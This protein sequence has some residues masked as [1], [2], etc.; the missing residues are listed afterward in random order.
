MSKEARAGRDEIMECQVMWEPDSKRTTQMD[1]FRAVA[2]AACGLA[3]ENYNDLYHWSVASYSDFWAEFWKFSGLVFSRMYDEVVDTSKGIAEVPEWFPGSRLNYAENLLQHAKNDRVALYVAR[4]GRE[5]I[6][7]LT[8]EE[9]RQ[10]VALFAAAMRKMGVR[11]GDRV[12]GY[13]PNGAHAVEA[14]LAAASIGAIWS[15]TSP[16]FGVNGVLDRFSQIQPKVLFSVEAVVYNGKEHSHMEKLQRVVRGLPDLKKVVVIPYVATRETIDISKIPNSV[17]LDDFLATGMG[18]QAPQLEFEQLPFN[19]PLFIMFSSGTT[20]A[21]KCMVHSAGGTLIQHLKEHLLHGD[22]TSGDVLLYY[23]TVGWM[24]WNWM[25]SALATGAS[26]VLYDGSP[27]VPTPNV[28]WDL[29]DRIGIT[30]LGTGAK[31]LSVLEEKDMK[32]VETHSLQTLR[33]ILSTGSPLKAQ[34]YDYVY[35]CIKSSVLLGSISGGTDIISCFMGHNPSIPVHRGEIQARN[36]AMAV[37]A[38][39]EE[40]RAVW[41]QS[42]EL[43]CTKPLPCQPTHFWNDEN[44]SKYRKAYFSKFPGVWAH[45]D[46]CRINPKTGG[47]VMLGRSD[48][49]LNPNG[50]RFGSSEIYNIVYAQWQEGGGGCETGHCGEG[51]GAAWGLLQPREPGPV[52]GHPRAAGLLSQLVCL[53][54]GHTHVHRTLHIPQSCRSLWARMGASRALSCWWVSGI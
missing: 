23:T 53:L 50:V 35:K 26:L 31:W 52:L 48:G 6:V 38:W 21:P 46:Y 9:L 32:P 1:R 8:F 13:L 28:L 25:V 17:F 10:Q 12:V 37:E 34:S 11:T 2:G 49:T 7:K 41:G 44:G 43:V 29:V 20:G 22:V 54:P 24:M 33:T 47:I 15:S 51:R 45:G 30:I 3:L 36:L 27:L 18:E 14:M 16:D 40:G 5:E 19:H 42:G 39:S 4:E